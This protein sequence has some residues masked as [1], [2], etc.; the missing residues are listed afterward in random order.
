MRTLLTS[1]A[2]ALAL[3]AGGAA[4]QTMV[5]ADTG[6]QATPAELVGQTVHAVIRN[7][8]QYEGVED[9]DGD[10]RAIGVIEGMSETGEAV[11]IALAEGLTREGEAA[12]EVSPELLRLVPVEDGRY[13]VLLDVQDT[14]LG[15]RLLEVEQERLAQ[16]SMA[17]G[18]LF[19]Q[20]DEMSG[21]PVAEGTDGLTDEGRP[22]DAGAAVDDEVEMAEAEPEVIVV[23][24][25]PAD[26]EEVVVVEPEVETETAGA[27][28]LREVDISDPDAPPI[29]DATEVVPADDAGEVT[30]LKAETELTSPTHT[31]AVTGEEADLAVESDASGT[32]MARPGVAPENFAVADMSTMD[33][34]ELLGVRVYTMDDD[35][36]GEIDRWIGE[37]PGRLPEGAVVDVGGVLGLGERQVAIDTSLMTLMADADGNDLRVYVEMTEQELDGLPEVAD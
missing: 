14:A 30:E 28:G 8:P 6:V 17:E 26:A 12:A 24:E 31:A 9:P 19:E 36:I 10:L 1:A 15:D 13:A 27:D 3:A 20:A 32:G 33:L 23:E 22:V 2:T 11:R 34:T 29:E 18:G 21:T 37:A 5:T 7:S 4:A 25:E 35:N 16:L